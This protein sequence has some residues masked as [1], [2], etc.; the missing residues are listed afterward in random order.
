MID[1]ITNDLSK[2]CIQPKVQKP[3]LKWVGGKT[4]IISHLMDCFPKE[5]NDYYEIFLG[6][7][8][9]LFALLS[10]KKEKLI[11]IH[12]NIYVYDLNEPLIYLY[13]NI[14][15]NHKELYSE[16]QNFMTV[17]KECTGNEVI[18]KATCIEEAKTSKE[19]YY[20]WLR[21]KY[22]K[23]NNEEQK[24]ILG[25]ALFLF[26]NKTCFRGVFR[27]GPNGFN[28]PY[29]HYKNPEIVN[30]KQLEDVHELIQDVIFNVADFTTSIQQAT[31]E[32]DFVYLDP[33]YAPEKDTSFVG[34]TLNG[35]N[36]KQHKSLFHLCH[37]HLNENKIKMMMSNSD[38]PITKE[39][40]NDESYKIQTISC[41][42]SIH[43]KKPGSKTN[44]IIVTNF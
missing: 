33:P 5:M 43:S 38:V 3:F 39:A 18:R 4:Q 2:L 27:I 21:N 1:D 12:G 9:V 36:V 30:M 32:D 41:K 24:S 19:S 11:K 28:V 6:G 15:T 8:S 37:S 25:S 14:Q 22:N 44:E 29:G 10:Y 34:Y 35:F 31:H 23:L 17:F 13:K 16:I 26:L 7:G 20:Y 42:R 40:F